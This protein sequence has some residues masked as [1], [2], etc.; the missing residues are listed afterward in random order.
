MLPSLAHSIYDPLPHSAPTRHSAPLQPHICTPCSFEGQMQAHT[1]LS[2]GNGENHVSG[3][4][5]SRP[6]PHAPGVG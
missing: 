1:H 4:G 2:G 5:G 3:W 6:R